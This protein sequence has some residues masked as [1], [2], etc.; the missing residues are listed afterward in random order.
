MGNGLLEDAFAVLFDVLRK[1]QC[2][3]ARE[4]LREFCIALFQRLYDLEMIFD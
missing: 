1:A 2:V 4:L 3:V